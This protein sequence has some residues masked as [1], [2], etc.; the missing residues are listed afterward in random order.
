MLDIH[1]FNNELKYPLYFCKMCTLKSVLNREYMGKSPTQG[2]LV[3][4]FSSLSVC[5][6]CPL[7]SR[8]YPLFV[9]LMSLLSWPL[10]SLLL[11]LPVGQITLI[12]TSKVLSGSLFTVTI[13]WLC[14]LTG[15]SFKSTDHFVSSYL[16]TIYV[17]FNLFVLWCSFVSQRVFFFFTSNDVQR[18]Y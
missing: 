9:V 10:G 4:L 16:L 3:F 7:F 13:L 6:L 18:Q 2:G 14:G 11:K 8:L 5:S 12:L 1:R 17:S 15:F